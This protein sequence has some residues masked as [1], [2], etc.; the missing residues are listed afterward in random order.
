MVQT[1]MTEQ[2]AIQILVDAFAQIDL[3]RVR[4]ALFA[5]GSRRVFTT[6][7]HHSQLLQMVGTLQQLQGD[8]QQMGLTLR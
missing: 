5:L 8:F 1:E 7:S 3:T 4:Q 6:F 2:E